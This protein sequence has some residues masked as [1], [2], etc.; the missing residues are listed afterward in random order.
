MLFEE[1]GYKNIKSMLE[2]FHENISTVA[3]CKQLWDLIEKNIQSF[4]H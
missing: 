1:I 2:K 4:E 3:L